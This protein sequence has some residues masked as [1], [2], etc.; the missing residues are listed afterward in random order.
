MWLY[1]RQQQQ[2]AAGWLA[3]CEAAAPAAAAARRRRRQKLLLLGGWGAG[4][5]GAREEEIKDSADLW[6]R[7]QL[8]CVCV[9]VSL[10]TAR[11]LCVGP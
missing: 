10:H 11:V 4:R 9:C 3:A 6:V 8:A 7:G 2:P 5:A 1:V